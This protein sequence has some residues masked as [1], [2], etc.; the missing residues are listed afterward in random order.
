MKRRFQSAA[1]H[2]TCP[3]EI[4]SWCNLINAWVDRGL[5]FGGEYAQSTS[6]F[7][8]PS[9][10]LTILLADDDNMLRD[11]LK[12]IL[13]DGGY[14]VAAE[15]GT[16]EATLEMCR[17]LRPGLVLLDINMPGRSGLSALRT[18]MKDMPDTKVIMISAEA[19]RE[20][21][22]EAEDHGAIGFIVKPFNAG[23][24]LDEVAAA[25][26]KTAPSDEPP[27]ASAQW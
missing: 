2:T 12:G 9:Q 21:V 11:L 4:R 5:L 26:A 6:G 15:A 13:R 20:R 25:F 18:I 7:D 8:M 14:E 10:K 3:A 17:K 24:V 23:R 22:Q 16:A 27:D 1:R 19:T